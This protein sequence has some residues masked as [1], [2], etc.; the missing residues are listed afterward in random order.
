MFT[1]DALIDTVQTGKKTIVNALV[2]LVIAVLA[3]QIV[4]FAAYLLSK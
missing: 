3:S 4:K 1:A 2:G